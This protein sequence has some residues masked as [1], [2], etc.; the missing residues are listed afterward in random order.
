MLPVRWLPVLSRWAGACSPARL[1]ILPPGSESSVVLGYHVPASQG[2]G[3]SPTLHV[4]TSGKQTDVTVT[5]RGCGAM[6]TSPRGWG[7][8]PTTSCLLLGWEWQAML[9]SAFH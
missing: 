7:S 1:P 9:P 3:S 8:S 4:S 6:L 5:V 2:E